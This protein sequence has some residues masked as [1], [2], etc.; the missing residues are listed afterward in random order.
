MAEIRLA[1]YKEDTTKRSN[2][3]S[4]IDVIDTL[5]ECKA[6]LVAHDANVAAFDAIIASIG[7][8]TVEAN[9]NA[10][11]FIVAQRLT[12]DK[13]RID[14]VAV[15][16]AKRNELSAINDTVQVNGAT[17]GEKSDFQYMVDNE[18]Y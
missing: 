14:L 1:D 18:A 17:T 6:D 13:E 15:I 3:K 9:L 5:D 2:F 16:T 7:N 10:V 8:A 12:W 11:D 4:A